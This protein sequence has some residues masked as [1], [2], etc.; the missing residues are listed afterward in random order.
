MIP[1]LKTVLR[2]LGFTKEATNQDGDKQMTQA[3]E[4]HVAKVTDKRDPSD[5]AYVI[6]EGD[7]FKAYT[8]AP[9]EKDAE[10]EDELVNLVYL[11][12]FAT[13]EEA[14]HFIMT[15]VTK[16]LENK[17]APFGSKALYFAEQVMNAGVTF[18]TLA[19]PK[20][21]GQDSED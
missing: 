21:S 8:G 14:E 4:F 11:D 5:V 7:P 13:H 12:T 3:K 9:T 17:G 19:D 10:H 1:F 20:N 6:K 2:F 15:T 18:F 16:P